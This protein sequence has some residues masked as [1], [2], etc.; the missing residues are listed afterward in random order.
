MEASALFA[1]AK[2]RKVNLSSLL[3]ASDSLANSEW[4]PNFSHSLT[5]NQQNKLARIAINV[6]IK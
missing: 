6:L 5:L 2:I 1:V 4:K 3:I